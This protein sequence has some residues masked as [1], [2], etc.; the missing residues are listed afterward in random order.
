MAEKIALAPPLTV[1]LARR[2]IGNLASPEVRASMDEELLAQ[3][4]L[5]SSPDFVEWK[6]AQAEQRAATERG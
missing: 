3:T 5:T 1:K 6:A 4:V 2:V